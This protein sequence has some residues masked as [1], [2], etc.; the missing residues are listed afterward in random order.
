MWANLIHLG[1]NMWGDVPAPDGSSPPGYSPTLRFDTD[2][3][4]E[5]VPAMCDA[6]VTTV[7]L[8][9]GDAIAY[10]SHP[11]I[12]VDGAWTPQQVRREVEQLA[13][14][15]LEAIP[16]LNFSARHDAW[17]GPYARMVSTPTY[18][19]VCVDLITEIAELFLTPRFFHLG[20]DE[21]NAVRQHALQFAVMRQHQLW[22]DDTLFL[23]DAVRQA[24]SRPWLWS[25]YAWQHPAEY[26]ERMPHDVV[27]SN[28]YYG[29]DFTVD[30]SRAAWSPV[31]EEYGYHTYLDLDGAGFTQVPTGSVW[32]HADSLCRTVDFCTP[33]LAPDRVLGYLQTPWVLTQAA[34][35][36]VH[37]Q[38]IEQIGLARQ[39][40][41]RTPDPSTTIDNGRAR[42]KRPHHG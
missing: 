30:P 29:T 7:V 8:D 1:S 28:W 16:K 17:L 40:Y 41:E 23:V 18:Y 15:G 14:V 38:A 22:W 19:Q 20:M 37:L 33:R 4:R 3:W 27:Q 5:L 24:G 32:S 2:L 35:R 13:A 26:A 34:Y 42:H 36:D 9:L 25:D 6:G 10:E 21:E 31:E 12:A 11:E 39:I